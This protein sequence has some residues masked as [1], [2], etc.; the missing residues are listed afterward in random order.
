[1]NLLKNI[2]EAPVDCLQLGW[3][4]L[5]LSESLLA[6]LKKEFNFASMTPVQAATIPLML[7][8]KDVIVEAKTGSGKTLAFLIPII[9]L[10]VRRDKSNKIH[11][12]DVLAL[13]LSPTRELATQIHQ[14]IRKILRNSVLG[15]D[16]SLGSLLIVG[17]S[18]V[19]SNIERYTKFGGNIII[20][21]PGRLSALMEMTD[22]RLSSSIRKNLNFLVFD[23]ADQLL[24]IGFEQNISS[25]LH[26]LPKQRRTSLFS[27][28][29]T[30]EVEDLIK[31]GLRNPIRVNVNQ[32]DEKKRKSRQSDCDP[33]KRLLMPNN[34]VNYYH[35]C[36]S[37]MQKLAT[38]TALVMM[39]DY[40]KV[41]VF[42]STCAQIDYFATCLEDKFRDKKMNLLKLHRRLKNKR[43]SIFKRFK[44]S[45][46]CILLA[47]DILSRGIDVTDISL[48]V[49]VDLP[50][51][52]ECYVHRSG[53]SGHQIKLSGISLLLLEKHELDYVE[54]CRRRQIEM[55]PMSIQHLTNEIDILT[56]K[57]SESIREK[58]QAD[59]D[60]RTLGM[61][62]FVSY[63]RYYSTKL[64]LR[65]LLY[66]KLSIAEL[67]KSF[68]L[69]KL[70]KMPEL[71]KTYKKLS[72]EFE[73]ND[74]DHA[75]QAQVDE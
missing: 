37:Y 54:M 73:M 14:V 33:S 59:T 63:I 39:D 16:R 2:E 40:K 25:I 70:P 27:A 20:A 58:A 21:T 53:R 26:Y 6:I 62:A 9:E 67:A 45:K 15:D 35:V 3:D 10:L 36:D 4:S 17:G 30:S 34:L 43:K 41:L 12:H 72:E 71:K 66:P 23:E 57:V 52:P 32:L 64:C 7:K 1:M 8:S 24:S 46:R 48:V 74:N 75:V 18:N 55:K 51:S 56:A 29:Q 49:H 61:Q 38:M 47:T 22:N 42:L 13:I 50:V 65:Q 28:T 60:Y 11:S 69:L 68:C 44:T 31:S 5:D 19:S